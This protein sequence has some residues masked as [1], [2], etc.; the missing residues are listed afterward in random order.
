MNAGRIIEVPHIV[1]PL[2]VEK[3]RVSRRQDVPVDGL[4]SQR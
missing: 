2:F 4:D 3:Y 1:T